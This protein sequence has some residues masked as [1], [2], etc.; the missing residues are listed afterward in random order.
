MGTLRIAIVIP[1]LN[2]A[3]SLPALLAEISKLAHTRGLA[4]TPVVV[5]DGSQDDSAA[6]AAASGAIVLRSHRNQG[7]ASA[8]QSGF[9]ATRDFDVVIT[10]DGDLQDDPAEIPALLAALEGAD[11]VS[12]WK[13]QRQDGLARRVQSRM[14]TWI[15][16]LFTGI[17]LHDFNCGLKAY[18][19]YVLDELH[20]YGDM[21][22]LIPVLVHQAGHRVAEIE[23]HH[24]PRLHGRSKYGIGRAVRGPLD[25]MT[26]VF[27]G[28]LGQRPLHLFGSIGG[29]F[30]LAGLGIAA[31]LT[32]IRLVAGEDI[33][34]RPLLLLGVLL[35]LVGIQLVATG[36]I[37]EMLLA[38][39]PTRPV[40]HRPVQ[41]AKVWELDDHAGPHDESATGGPA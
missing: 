15:V 13:K 2:E 30:A 6:V 21:H 37:A 5:D 16:R 24:R 12:G 25:L 33:G 36:L 32:W 10:M 1:V 17:D 14:Y 20:I 31:Y 19:R 35:I 23:V 7:K 8:L 9:D 4:I 11:L 39:S 22:R 38:T 28:R 29:V 26:V 18:R 41:K 40:P 34:D 3:D 27:L